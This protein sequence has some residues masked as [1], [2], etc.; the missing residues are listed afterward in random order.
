MNVIALLAAGLAA[1]CVSYVFCELVRRHAPAWGLL[2]T[3]GPRSSHGGIT[4]RG[5]GVGVFAGLL[6]GL[7]AGRWW[8]GP[9]EQDA[10]VLVV[11]AIF[12]VALGVWDDLQ[13]LSAWKRL[14]IHGAVAAAVVT[15]LG[16]IDRLPLPSPLDV[17]LGVLGRPLTALWIVV[18]A[19]FFNFMDGI[20]GLAGAQAIATAAVVIASGWSQT[21][22]GLAAALLGGVAG[23]LV[24][25]WPPA[26]LFL[27][28]AGS[29]PLGF[30]L[31]ALP[32]LAPREARPEALFAVAVSL[33]LF[34]LDPLETLIR[35]WRR[36]VRVTE[37]HRDHSYQ[38]LVPPGSSHRP[39]TVSLSGLVLALSVAGALAFRSPGWRWPALVLAASAFVL[40]V[41]GGERASRPEEPR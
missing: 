6:A 17:P 8:A 2:D 25:N 11:G 15:A 37:S 12:L 9:L 13:S 27:G 33:A 21:A 28:D 26:R 1:A 5:G 30:L 24:L 31:A 10:L 39:A 18:V 7:V 23:F 4:P 19:N 35:R 14:A 40:E 34:L 36:G 38:R 32:L 22:S 41:R 3:P 29:V 16:G 20:D